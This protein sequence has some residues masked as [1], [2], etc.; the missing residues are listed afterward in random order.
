MKKWLVTILSAAAA[1][2]VAAF[3]VW[4][5]LDRAPGG[6]G[7][8]HQAVLLSNGQVYYGKLTGLGTRFP[9]LTDV[10]Y[11]QS[12]MDPQ[13]RETKSVLVKRGKEWHGPDRMVLNGGQILLI[14]PV[15]AGSKVAELIRASP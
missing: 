1:G 15:T 6:L 5:Y 12:A 10:Y 3:L 13:T 2:A 4:S 8:G 14:E 7:N 11:V 9:V